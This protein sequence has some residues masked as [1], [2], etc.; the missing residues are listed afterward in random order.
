GDD[1]FDIR[2]ISIAIDRSFR[3]ATFADLNQDGD[4]ELIV[5]ADMIR[6]Y[7]IEGDDA[8]QLAELPG[9]SALGIIDFDGNGSVDIM[10]G[11]QAWGTVVVYLNQGG[12][13][14]FREGFTFSSESGG[15]IAGIIPGDFDGD[16]D[17]D[18]IATWQDPFHGGSYRPFHD[19][20]ENNGADA[21]TTSRLAQESTIFTADVTG[22]GSPDIIFD[23]GRGSITRRSAG[24]AED[25]AIIDEN[26]DVV[27]NV[28]IDFDNDGDLDFVIGDYDLGSYGAE[29]RASWFENLGNGVFGD[30]QDIGTVWAYYQNAIFTSLNVD[31]VDI[32]FDGDLDV[33]FEASD[34][35]GVHTG[36]WFL[37]HGDQTFSEQRTESVANFGSRY[38][39]DVDSDGRVDLIGRSNTGAPGLT[40]RRRL[41][42]GQLGDPSRLMEVPSTPIGVLPGDFNGDGHTDYVVWL[43]DRSTI[44]MDFD[45]EVGQFQARDTKVVF[46]LGDRA[47]DVDG[48]GWLDVVTTKGRYDR[49]EPGLVKWYKNEGGTFSDARPI[50]VGRNRP[51]SVDIVDVD[52][53]GDFDLVIDAT[54]WVIHEAGEFS[55]PVT[56]HQL[57]DSFH[58]SNAVYADIDDDGDIDMFYRGSW[59]EQRPVG[60]SNGDGVFDSSDFVIAFRSGK[61]ESE[62]KGNATFQEGDWNGDGSFDSSDLV[63]AFQVGAYVR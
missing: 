56:V 31:V 35:Y 54:D 39:F 59:F 29:F 25:V 33:L 9:S 19:V 28:V 47:V 42:D 12:G 55:P 4:E 24:A 27:S 20:H 32:E 60:D 51:E 58:P 38:H 11:G 62:V 15:P 50:P 3:S 41:A 40:W 16:G 2:T 45:E 22:D 6:I 21:V 61:Y 63:T 5:Q 8:T 26:R 43:L 14:T 53:D 10:T 46:D 37:N 7:D 13:T 44:R 49:Y 23:D 18:W 17:I 36:R 1:P 30:R 52:A 34:Q 57:R 48:D